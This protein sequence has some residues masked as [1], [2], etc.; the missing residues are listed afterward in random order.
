M[1]KVLAEVTGSISFSQR[2]DKGQKGALMREHDGFESAAISIFRVQK[3]KNTLMLCVLKAS[4]I[5]V[6]K[7][8]TLQLL[9]LV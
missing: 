9:R 1:T 5:N 8:M 2:G 3:K 7:R 4:G 6:L